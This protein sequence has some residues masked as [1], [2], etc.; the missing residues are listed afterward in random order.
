MNVEQTN[1]DFLSAY[2]VIAARQKVLA[3]DFYAGLT[4]DAVWSMALALNASQEPLAAVNKTLVDFSYD[5]ADTL[6]Q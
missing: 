2:H 4:Y 1:A 6:T 5:D 3:A